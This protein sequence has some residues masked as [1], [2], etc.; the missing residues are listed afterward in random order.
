M[1]ANFD[2][3]AWGVA[4]FA[5]LGITNLDQ[6]GYFQFGNPYLTE[7]A[8]LFDLDPTLGFYPEY[9]AYATH[10]ASLAGPVPVR[11]HSDASL[12]KGSC[13]GQPCSALTGELPA[14]RF[15]KTPLMSQIQRQVFMRI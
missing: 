6:I 13:G 5:L 9:W 1:L 4:C 14:P 3:T 15:A 12:T 11:D 7:G 2:T 10:I 8:S